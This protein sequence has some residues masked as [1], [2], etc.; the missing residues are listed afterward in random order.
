[1]AW[2]M[3]VTNCMILIDSTYI[4]GVYYLQS[5]LYYGENKLLSLVLNFIKSIVTNSVGGITT[6]ISSHNLSE[7]KSIIQEIT[8][9]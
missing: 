2:M 4:S 6:I 1:M 5:S 8:N 7:G 9:V 3:I